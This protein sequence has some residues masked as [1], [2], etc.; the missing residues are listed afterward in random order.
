MIAAILA[1][2]MIL[3]AVLGEPAWL[4]SRL[5]HPAVVMGRAIGWADGLF[6]RGPLRRLT[7]LAVILV[8]AAAAGLVGWL[9]GRLPGAPLWQALLAAILLAQRSLADH[10]ADVA[11]ALR[12]STAEGRIAVAR[13]VG[14]DTEGIEPPAI[15]RAAIESAAENL[16]D[17]V[18]APAFWFLIAGLPGLM[19]YKLVNTADSMIGHR[20]PRHQ[21][22][23]WAAAR[24]DD[25]LNLIPARLTAL[26]IWAIAPRP[27]AGL[28]ILQDAPRHR[29]PNAGWPEAA[30]A[31]ALG[32][33]LAGPRSYGGELRDFAFV[34]ARGR[35]DLGPDDIDR[36]VR[37]L[38]KVWALALA[39]TLLIAATATLTR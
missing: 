32:I 7:G 12:R 19:I 2:A 38:W 21:A 25:A 5:P 23:G 24:L 36:T 13:I 33:A 35:H 28:V 6:N 11:T 14:R 27:G 16:S 31:T 1:A 22:F 18:I 26:M 39:L 4:W 15:A 37:L 30:T 29:S 34:N 10:V 3:D 17:G 20:T 8:L 9:V